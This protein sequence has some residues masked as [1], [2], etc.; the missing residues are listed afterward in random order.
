[1]RH[2]GRR[3]EYWLLSSGTLL[4][5]RRLSSCRLD[6]FESRRGRESRGYQ[7]QDCCRRS[8]RLMATGHHLGILKYRDIVKADSW[9]GIAG[10]ESCLERG[11]VASGISSVSTKKVAPQSGP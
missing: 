4:Q 8:S 3:K 2:I 1:M 11:I 5:L 9:V 6:M 10:L 7:V